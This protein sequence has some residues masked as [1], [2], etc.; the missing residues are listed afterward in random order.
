M[1]HKVWDKWDRDSLAD[2]SDAVG[3][4]D[5]QDELRTSWVIVGAAAAA[6]AVVSG[7]AR[8]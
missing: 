6:L 5:T 3:D 2:C 7:I 4:V 1:Q 8:M